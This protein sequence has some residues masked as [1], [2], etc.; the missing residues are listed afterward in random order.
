MNKLLFNANQRD[1][2]VAL[3]IAQLDAMQNAQLQKPWVVPLA[4][5]PANY[6]RPTKAYL[7][8]N[9]MLLTMLCGVEGWKCPLFLTHKQM[10]K[11]GLSLN[12]ETDKD[13]I[14][15]FKDNG[16]PQY[17]KP[18]PVVYMFISRYDKDGNKLTQDD[19]DALTDDEKAACR[20]R[21]YQ[22]FYSE[23]NLG[24]TN[25]A[26]LY[27][28][29]WQELTALPE[30]PFEEGVRDEVLDAMIFG[31]KWRCPIN[32]GGDRACF[33]PSFDRISLPE[34]ERFMGDAAFYGTALHE[35]AHSTCKAVKREIK[36]SF[37][38]SDYAKEEFIAELTAACVGALLGVGKLLDEQ[39]MAYVQGWRKA[40]C[41]EKDYLQDVIN[42]VEDASDYFMR[43][44][45]KLAK[46]MAAGLKAA[47]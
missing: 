14:P 34:R 12:I 13:G 36:G 17:E 10:E 4:A 26:E 31:G 23:F 28:E 46:E 33:S 25:F 37:G 44:Y 32:F 3:F 29:K 35:M 21:W 45:N 43:E 40:I 11:L 7:G 42:A 24:Q 8:I 38:S 5:A 19:Y 47:A 1:K 27:P 18:W 30:H 6:E 39:H 2:F 41:E 15:T 20:K 16:L 22:K 9:N